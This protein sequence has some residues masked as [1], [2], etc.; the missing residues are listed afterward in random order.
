MFPLY[1]Y[2]RSVGTGQEHHSCSLRVM[3]WQWYRYN[4]QSRAQGESGV[5]WRN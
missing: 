2:G 5:V 4:N 1:D 3:Y